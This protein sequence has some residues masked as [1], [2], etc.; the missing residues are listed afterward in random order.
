MTLI[1]NKVT[2]NL[3]EEERKAIETVKKL[4]N[5]LYYGLDDHETIRF[6][7]IMRASWS[8]VDDPNCNDI[9]VGICDLSCLL[10][11]FQK[12]IDEFNKGINPN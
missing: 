4:T 12:N 2:I 5:D 8:G 10:D 3:T 7:D 6:N 11:D 9:E 1:R